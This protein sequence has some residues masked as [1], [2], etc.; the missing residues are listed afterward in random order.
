LVLSS[1]IF[2]DLNSNVHTQKLKSS[3]IFRF[4]VFWNE[5]LCCWVNG[6]QNFKVP[7]WLHFQG[8]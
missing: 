1:P 6:L 5:M 8:Q 7:C 4:W 2:M 3:E